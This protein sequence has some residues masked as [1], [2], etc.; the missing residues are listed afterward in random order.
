MSA[1]REPVLT[2]GAVVALVTALLAVLAAFGL[3]L[4]DDQTTAVVSLISVVA[5]IVVA[6][7]ARP[8][9]TP[10]ADPKTNDGTPLVPLD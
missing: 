10:L 8:K 6:L 2:A 9:V 5:P 4:T 3:P 7:L 1:D